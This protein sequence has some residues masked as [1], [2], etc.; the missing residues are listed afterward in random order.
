MTRPFRTAPMKNGTRY[1]AKGEP[2]TEGERRED[3]PRQPDPFIIGDD[4]DFATLLHDNDFPW[5]WANAAMAVLS[6]H[7]LVVVHPPAT[8][9][10]REDGWDE[11]RREIEA[12]KA[13]RGDDEWDTVARQEVLA[14]LDR[15]A[16]TLSPVRQPD[17][18]CPRCG[19]AG[20]RYS[21]PDCAEEFGV[22]QERAGIDVERP[23]KHAS[24]D[25][26]ACR[27]VI[28]CTCNLAGHEW[29]C[30]WN[31]WRSPFQ[32]CSC[33]TE[34]EAE[35]WAP[36]VAEAYNGRARLADPQGPTGDEG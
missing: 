8:P 30:A 2:M 29:C 17:E 16:A 4:V 12:L 34:D 24:R 36:H 7:N 35:K 6:H 5:E 1:D 14:I 18:P 11:L 19:R 13:D 20:A 15:L 26:G 32:D 31:D 28:S 10:R 3:G 23:S 22:R 9:E 25:F 21:C 33:F 27:H